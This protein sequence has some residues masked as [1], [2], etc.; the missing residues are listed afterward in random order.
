[1]GKNIIVFSDGTGQ[2]GGVG[3]NT[4]VYKL[5]NMIEQRTDRQIA[6]YDP[7]LGTDW[8]RITGAISG[9]GV[10]Q[11]ILECY[12]FIFE[13][14]KAGDKIYL[15]GFSRGAAT[16]RSL[17]AFIHMFGI[18]PQSR[19]DLIKEAFRIYK[20]RD[21]EKRTATAKALIE[22]NNTMWTKIEFLGVWDTVAALGLPIGGLGP[23]V[24]FF[25]PHRFHSFDLSDAV[26][27]ARHALSIDE[28]RKSFQPVLWA[29]LNS[30]PA[31]RMKQVWFCGVHTDVGGGY[32]E[33]DLSNIT[34]KWMIK[35]ATAK[36]LLIY[37]KSTL[38]QKLESTN[39]NVDGFMHDQRRKF[40]WKMMKG[41]Q[42][43]WPTDYGPV[44]IHESVTQ[45]TRDRANQH[46]PKYDAWIIKYS[47]R[48]LEK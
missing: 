21:H 29:P 40:P 7:G 2:K 18:L 23:L 48:I 15:F 14:F 46:P 42:R 11:N 4:N 27:H 20:I 32:P 45:R 30:G 9:R 22:N 13:Q 8:R 28:E 10:S 39:A 47:E 6:Y 5:F 1:M 24:D 41:V 19:P 33:E 43:K 16:V 36:G 38:Y 35:E 34:L 37:P 31:D 3:S 17:S 26:V 12:R 25:F 44:C